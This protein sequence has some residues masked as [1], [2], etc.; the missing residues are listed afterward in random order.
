MKEREGMF[1]IFD[2]ETTGFIEGKNI[3]FSD[4]SKFPR[5]VQLAFQIHSKEGKLIE[6][7]SSIVKPEGFEIPYASAKV[8][9]ITTERAVAEGKSLHNVMDK[10]IAALKETTVLVG[11]NIISFDILVFKAELLRLAL[12]SDIDSKIIIDT[13]T[14]NEIVNYCQLAGGRGAGYKLPKLEELY[15]KLFVEKFNLAHNAA[16]DVE[17]NA[18]A[19]FELLKRNIITVSGVSSNVIQYEAPELTDL[20]NY[21]KDFHAVKTKEA[22]ALD[23]QIVIEKQIASNLPFVSLHNHTVY[24][25]GQST[26]DVTDLVKKAAEYNMKGL[27]ITDLGY[28]AGVMDFYDAIKSTN[29]SIQKKNEELIK[30]G[31][32]AKQEIKPIIGCEFYL[33]DNIFDKNEKRYNYQTP[34]LAKNAIGYSNLC[35]LSSLAFIDGFYYVPRIDTER[36]LQNKEGLI[37][38]S[39]WIYGEIPQ[40]LMKEGEQKA[41]EKILWYKE[42]FAENFYLELNDHGLEDEKYINEFLIRMSKKHNIKAIAANNN[43][44]LNM[45]HGEYYDVLLCV[46]S[47]E[48]KS[49]PIG[50]GSGKRDGLLNNEFYFKTPFQM[51]QLFSN[52]P[53]CI[54]NTSQLVDTIEVFPVEK[55]VVLPQF[56]IPKDFSQQHSNLNG[57]DL[58]CEYLKYLAYQ[59]AKRKYQEIDEEVKNRLDYELEVIKKMGF[60]GYFLIVSDILLYGRNVGIRIGP[61]RGSAAGSIVAYCLDITN[62]DPIK[63][64]LL[65]ERFLNPDRISMP[66]IDIDIADDRREELIE[67]IIEKYGRER[68]ANIITFATLGGKSAIRD[69]ARTLGIEPSDINRIAKEFG[70]LEDLGIDNLSDLNNPDK[71]DFTTYADS[72]QMSANQLKESF[73]KTYNEFLKSDSKSKEILKYANG[74]NGCFRHTAKHACGL[75]I[76]PK[77][78][79]EIAPLAKD[80]KSGQVITQFNVNV[81]EKAGLL[82]MDFLGLTTLSIITETLKYIKEN[83]G[84]DIDIDSIS[85][86]DK[87]TYNIF[88]NAHTDEIFQFESP[89]MKKHLKNLKPDAINDL[90][91]M[92]ALYRPGPMKYIDSYIKRKHGVEKIEYELPEME[93]I[94]KETYGITV[95]QEQVM[96]L[97]QRLA[98]F[99][100]G[101][102][103]ELRKAMG[104]KKLDVLEKMSKDFF[105]GCEKNNLDLKKVEKIW[106]DWKDFAS[107]A[108][109]KSHSV[110][111]TLLAYQT[112]YL[113]AHFPSEFMCASLNTKTSTESISKVLNECKRMKIQILPPDINE[114]DKKFKAMK[115]G[116]IRFGISMI[117]NV[118]ENFADEVIEDREKNGEFHHVFELAERLSSKVLNKKNIENLAY[119]GALDC[120]KDTTRA[121]FLTAGKDGITLTEKLSKYADSIQKQKTTQTTSLFDVSAS[122]DDAFQKQYPTV[123]TISEWD[124]KT[125]LYYENQVTGF[126]ISGIPL[127]EYNILLKHI[128]TIPI[129]EINDNIESYKDKR[130]SLAGWIVK[131]ERGKTK[132]GK[133]FMSITLE[134]NSATTKL[135]IREEFANV[136]KDNSLQSLLVR[137]NVEVSKYTERTEFRIDKIYDLEDVLLRKSVLSVWVQVNQ[138]TP[139]FINDFQKI[140]IRSQSPQSLP[141]TITISDVSRVNFMKDNKLKVDYNTDLLR[142]FDKYKLDYKLI[143]NLNG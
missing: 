51:Q 96:L 65:F 99:T 27:A 70:K 60:P 24:S 142:F 132:T 5:I 100:K 85:L 82:K 45:E 107:Y 93:E 112:A 118:G 46:K 101:Q 124:F 139:Q 69:T 119:A 1:L 88:K 64:N 34:I 126:Y 111:Y 58:E 92:N 74:I 16:F 11:H 26:T 79:S 41:E 15:E 49:K 53:E 6:Q 131:V 94:L 106:E 105:E 135:Y 120:F 76:A 95:Y 90:V 117:K 125:K 63:Y 86:S 73:K 33:C 84:L 61:G 7:Y 40:V 17:A 141:F 44:Y 36:L 77:N 55:P 89:G 54:E 103:D 75:I 29:K 32:P 123:E 66:D 62:V 72:S 21:E 37:V 12:S 80:T 143:T 136:I 110:C 42:A 52:F 108:F 8:H 134:D 104:K 140:T 102:A 35:K 81:A 3:D 39:G 98:G 23:S 22:N 43:F 56:E 28:M 87:A 68:V 4:L 19:F 121:M 122:T 127:D 48:Q 47:G 31:N 137:G 57:V 114:S 97:S 25:V 67:Y 50:K 91:A 71:I 10:F 115:N 128:P 20:Y 138:I 2:V 113:K 13:C 83:K 116:N 30:Q 78:L 109:N 38:L 18:H 14:N 59:G 129:S 9:K 130:V 133:P